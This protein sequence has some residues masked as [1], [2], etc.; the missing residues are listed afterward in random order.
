MVQHVDERHE[1]WA[2]G[3]AEQARVGGKEA[4][5]VALQGQRALREDVVE[6]ADVGGQALEGSRELLTKRHDLRCRLR[7]K[8]ALAPRET[9]SRKEEGSELQ[10]RRVVP[11]MGE[12]WSSS[13]SASVHDRGFAENSLGSVSAQERERERVRLAQR[14]RF[15]R[16]A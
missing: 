8:R 3:G 4:P 9:R 12:A 13:R 6:L 15:S 11:R 5:E 16:S 2:S 1:D 10:V 7:K 14:T